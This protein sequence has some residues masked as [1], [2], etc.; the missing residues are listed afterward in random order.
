MTEA[1]GCSPWVVGLAR[2]I[3]NSGWPRQLVGGVQS[4]QSHLVECRES[5]FA[6][7]PLSAPS[8][9]AEPI[10]EPRNFGFG[11]DAGGPLP[12]PLLY[13]LGLSFHRFEVGG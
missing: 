1:F 7:A 11:F 4:G 13:G 3:S 2:I 8:G 10:S 9:T 5:E 6:M 12:V